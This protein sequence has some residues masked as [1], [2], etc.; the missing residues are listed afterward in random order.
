MIKVV[1]TVFPH[2]KGNAYDLGKRRPVA[3]ANTT[4]KLWTGMVTR[5]LTKHAEHYDMLSSSQ[6]GLRAEKNN[7]RQLQN[8]MN[9]MSDA[10]I[11]IYTFGIYTLDFGLS[12]IM[13]S[14]CALCMTL[15]SHQM[16]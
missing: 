12:L 5:C 3:L 9:V 1:G 4:Y 6:E 7:I 11:R 15:A 10:K 2:K 16:P 13:T 8:L 14:C